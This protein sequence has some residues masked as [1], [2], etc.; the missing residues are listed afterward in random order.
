[1]FGVRRREDKWMECRSQA[2]KCLNFKE[3]H[4]TLAMAYLIKRKLIN[5]KKEDRERREKRQQ[6]R[7]QG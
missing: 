5:R 6:G 4:R 3:A 7:T 2:K 1:M